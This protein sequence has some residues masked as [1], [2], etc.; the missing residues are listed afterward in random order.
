MT[1]DSSKLEDG[2]ELPPSAC[3]GC[4]KIVDAATYAGRAEK[5]PRPGDLSVCMYC[6]HP[7]IYDGEGKLAPINL[8][9]LDS[10][11][12]A[13]IERVRQVILDQRKKN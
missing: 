11:D 12:R 4:G 3:L 13:G 7:A 6:A 10:Q 9:Q 1:D 8:S 2:S 5:R